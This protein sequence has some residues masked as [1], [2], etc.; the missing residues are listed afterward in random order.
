MNIILASTS[1]RR[2]EMLSWL[3]V[4]FQAE[5]PGI[6][7]KKI[8][9]KNPRKLARKLAEAKAEVVAKTHKEGLTIAADTVTFL[10][11]W[12]IEKPKSVNHQK[13]LLK[14]QRGRLA[15][16]ITAICILD[17]SN[18][19]KLIRTSTSLIKMA[20][21]SNKDIEKYIESGQG[22]NK[23]GGYGAQDENGLFIE[24]IKGSYTGVIGFPLCLVAGMLTSFGLKINVDVNKVIQEK[25]GY[26]C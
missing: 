11:G 8:R 4:K 10:N 13:R 9:D 21:V 24:N 12:L 1:P 6:D 20:K 22:L 2:I 3:G 16:V 18:R 17:N 15:K 26:K 19:K 7:E 23:G 25:T 14:L 5:S